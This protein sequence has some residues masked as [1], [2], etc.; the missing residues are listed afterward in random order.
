[1]DADSRLLADTLPCSRTKSEP[2]DPFLEKSKVPRG[3]VCRNGPV[4]ILRPKRSAGARFSPGAKSRLRDPFE[5]CDRNEVQGAGSGPGSEVTPSRP[6]RILR[7][8]RSAGSRIRTC[9]LLRDRILSPTPLARL[10][11]PCVDPACRVGN[12]NPPIGRPRRA[13]GFGARRRQHPG[14]TLNDC[15]PAR[16]HPVARTWQSQAGTTRAISGRGTPASA[17]VTSSRSIS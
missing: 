17:W 5:S 9:E 14:S 1:M 6:V 15:D 11:Y 13:S 16:R 10:G 7:P 8:K 3:G 2:T 12:K 4:R